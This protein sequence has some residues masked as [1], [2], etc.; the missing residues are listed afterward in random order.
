LLI[1]SIGYTIIIADHPFAYLIANRKFVF[2]SSTAGGRAWC[3]ITQFPVVDGVGA[4]IR[5]ECIFIFDTEILVFST[6]NDLKKKSND[7]LL[8]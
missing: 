5:W 8:F 4:Q 6:E 2:G 7:F 1:L 3:E